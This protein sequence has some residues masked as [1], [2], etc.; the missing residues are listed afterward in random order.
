MARKFKVGDHVRWNSKADPVSGSIIAIRMRDF[1]YKSH[2]HST[3]ED[4]PRFGQH[5]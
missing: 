3:F 1:D 2:T 4:E 5:C